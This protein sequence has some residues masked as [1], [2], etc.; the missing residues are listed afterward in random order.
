MLFRSGVVPGGFSCSGDCSLSSLTGLS[1]STIDQILG[2]SSSNGSQGS[3]S[4][5]AVA[6]SNSTSVGESAAQAGPAPADSSAQGSP[7][8]SQGSPPGVSCDGDGCTVTVC[9]ACT[10]LPAKATATVISIQITVGA[11]QNLFMAPRYPVG[12]NKTPKK[13]CTNCGW[14]HSGTFGDYCPDCQGKSLDPNGGVPPNPSWNGWGDD[15]EE[16]LPGL[17]DNSSRYTSPFWEPLLWQYLQ[18][19]L[20]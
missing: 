10:S 2:G 15:D 3:S 14:P 5:P 11:M 16:P 7:Q 8:G 9:A 19:L 6:G 12:W 13:G 18:Y 20:D 1:Q 4:G 17:D